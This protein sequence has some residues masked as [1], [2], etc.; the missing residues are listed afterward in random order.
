MQLQDITGQRIGKIVRALKHIESKI[1]SLVKTFGSG[2]AVPK[3]KV[4]EGPNLLEGPALPGGGQ[5]QED[6]DKLLASFD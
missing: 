5:S 4:E 1:E 6:I 3:P 2:A